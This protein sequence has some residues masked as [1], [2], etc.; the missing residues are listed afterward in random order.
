M[1]QG[2]RKQGQGELSPSLQQINTSETFTEL[3]LFNLKMLVLFLFFV[4][5]MLVFRF[6]L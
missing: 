5:K 4:S 6:L 1:A 3:R 2:V